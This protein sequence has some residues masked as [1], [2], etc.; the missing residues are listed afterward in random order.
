MVQVAERRR[1]PR[2][3]DGLKA[4]ILGKGIK[5]LVPIIDMSRHGALL[6][7]KRLIR[8]GESVDLSLYLPLVSGAIG[9]KARV[10]RVEAVCYP[11]GFHKFH[12]G[13][14]FMNLVRAQ[15]EMLS[16]ACDY[17]ARNMEGER[18][19]YPRQAQAS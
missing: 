12:I 8:P 6:K 1:S 15:Q 14:E 17:L 9:I 2:Y 3:K 7:T 10:A 11:W 4:R 18:H 13:L 19:G 5:K 16:M